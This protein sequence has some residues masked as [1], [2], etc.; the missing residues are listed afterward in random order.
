MT[1]GDICYGWPAHASRFATDPGAVIAS[2]TGGQWQPHS[3]RRT[4]ARGSSGSGRDPVPDTCQR[5]DESSRH[6]GAPPSAAPRQQGFTLI[7]LLA[8]L[9]ITAI[10]LGI[11]LPAI[12]GMLR[13]YRLK[14]AAWD[15]LGAVELAR[16]QAIASGQIV[17]LAPTSETLAW[18]DGWTVFI[19]RNGN[20]RPDAGDTIL[21]RH[22][23]LAPGISVSMH[24]GTQQGPPYLA[25]NSAGRGC[26]HNNSLAARFGTLTVA[27][28]PAMRR[29]KI[30]MLGRARLCDPARDAAM[31]AGDDA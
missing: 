24:F 9:A 4:P 15:M 1:P 13:S 11:A 6:T 29:I 2:R 7:E 14:L 26:K 23:A 28:R 10:L 17:L 30:N 18:S 5:L 27:D 12:G 20:R 22:A 3:R 19:D 8:V 16:G 25:Y 21:G 31:C